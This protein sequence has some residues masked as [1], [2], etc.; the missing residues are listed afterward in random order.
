ML[1]SRGGPLH[2]S[3]IDPTL[4][5]NF[6]IALFIGALVGVDRERRAADQH[7][8]G[9]LRTFVLISLSGAC[10]SWLSSLLGSP[11]LVLVGLFGLVVLLSVAYATTSARGASAGLTG[12][13]AAIVVYLLGAACGIGQPEVAVVVGITTSALLAFK[14]PL[15]AIVSKVGEED[16]AAALKLL[17]ATFIVLP[18]LPGTAVDPWGA[19]VPY[20]LWWLVILVSGLSLLGYAAVRLVGEQR[21]LLLTGLF[22]GLVSS[23]AVT[24]SAARQS[25]SRPGGEDALAMSVTAAWAVMFVRV[26]VEVGV[27]NPALLP[28]VALPMGAAALACAASVGWLAQKDGGPRSEVELENP[29]SL[30]EASKVA[31]MFAGVRLIVQISQQN[32]PEG[33][34]YGI[35]AIA[36]MTDVDAITLSMADLGQSEALAGTAAAAIVISSASNTLVKLGLVLASGT[37]VLAARMAAV[38]A[39]VALAGTLGAIAAFALI[40]GAR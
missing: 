15:H 25:A 11:S 26:M 40:G 4:M 8:F 6:A 7:I 3:S 2:I 33:A 28:H 29:F 34:L 13:V 22:G 5:R 31:A 10:A 27:V 39:L 14:Q 19:I 21:G 9:G 32:A 12:E 17:F 30:W 38:A 23:T 36:G 37:R 20:K 35:A 1:P 18:L 16:L 24:L